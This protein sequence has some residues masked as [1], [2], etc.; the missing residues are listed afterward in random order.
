[1]EWAWLFFEKEIYYND[2]E[3]NVHCRCLEV[4][5]SITQ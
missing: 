1:M 3:K 5:N 4:N 2:S